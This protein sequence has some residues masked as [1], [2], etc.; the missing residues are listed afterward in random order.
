MKSM[1]VLKCAGL[2]VLAGALLASG[3]ARKKKG[4]GQTAGDMDITDIGTGSDV[5][6][7][8][9]PDELGTRITDVTFENVHFAYDN[10][11]IDQAEEAKI[12]AVS[13]YMTSNP[14]VRLVAEGHCD[15]RGS[16]EYNMTLGEHRA[17]AVRAYLVSL[18]IS[19][20]RI[21]TRSYGED[22]PLDPSQSEAAYSVN[23]RVEFALYR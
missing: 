16:R 7:G 9:R 11:Q 22:N 12:E 3:C 21:Q 1:Y 15:E 13:A 20:D 4:P 19:G 23:R 8:A 14:D 18:G 17:Q 10:Y 6:M 5:E 2:V